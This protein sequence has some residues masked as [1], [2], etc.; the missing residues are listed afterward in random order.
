MF[1]PLESCVLKGYKNM[2]LI[3]NMMVDSYRRQ[4]AAFS[5]GVKGDA[6]EAS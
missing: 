2:V 3:H 6:Y 4:S 1:T 5:N